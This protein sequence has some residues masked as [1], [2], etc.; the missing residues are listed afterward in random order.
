MDCMQPVHHSVPVLQSEESNIRKS[1][2]CPYMYQGIRI[3]EYTLL[4]SAATLWCSRLLL[5][6]AF[7]IL[8]SREPQN[9]DSNPPGL[10]PI[11]GLFG[12]TCSC[13]N[14]HPRHS[15]VNAVFSFWCRSHSAYTGILRSLIFDQI[16]GERVTGEPSISKLLGH[17]MAGTG[18]PLLLAVFLLMANSCCIDALKHQYI[19]ARDPCVIYICIMLLL[20]QPHGG[21]VCCPNH[22]GRASRHS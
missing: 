7:C 14:S 8:L 13:D 5:N 18:P 16:F 10:P 22:L 11:K 2:L 12:N 9:V 6:P 4:F 19:C 21:Q 3:I 17:G 1:T 20:L 15:Q